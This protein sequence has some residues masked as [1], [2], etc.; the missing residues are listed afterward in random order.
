MGLGVWAV[1]RLV[2]R[3]ALGN[4]QDIIAYREG[5]DGDDEKERF[6]VKRCGGW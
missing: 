1:D 6:H 4:Q 3:W 2:E 5:G